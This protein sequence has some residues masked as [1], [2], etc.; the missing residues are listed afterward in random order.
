MV[1]ENGLFIEKELELLELKRKQLIEKH[2]QMIEEKSHLI[3]WGVVVA[4]MLQ[5]GTLDAEEWEKSCLRHL[6]AANL[7]VAI[8]ALKPFTTK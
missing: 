3:Q 1:T 2:E 4:A 8:A 5:E 6:T 7:D